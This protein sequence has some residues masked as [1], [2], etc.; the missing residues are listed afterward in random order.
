[1]IKPITKI[2]VFTVH[3]AASMFLHQI[4]IEA[5]AL[6]KINYYSPN[7]KQLS[8]SLFYFRP[9][10]EN[11]CQ[12][13][14]AKFNSIDT[15]CIGPMRYPLEIDL[16][17]CFVNLHL[18][19]PRDGLNSMFFSW[20]KIHK[21]FD[22][23]KRDEWL[24]WGI[25]KFVIS[26]SDEYLDRYEKYLN[27]FIGHPNVNLLKYEDM[28]YNFDSWLTLFVQ[29]FQ[30]YSQDISGL[31]KQLSDEV[32]PQ[33]ADP[34]THRRKMISGDFKNNLKPETIDTLN[35]KFGHI[36]SALDYL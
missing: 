11:F 24:S 15:G 1:M 36:L 16:D 21:G 19:D 14:L 31:S 9:P 8:D 7:N 30:L 27:H 2:A 28:V 17:S 25:D 13:A 6:A 33:N 3:K 23:S 5:S 18:R 29:P 32:N 10:R 4:T 12:E 20:T 26:F 34:N 22:Q 35:Q